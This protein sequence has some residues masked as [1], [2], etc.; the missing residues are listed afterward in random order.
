[1]LEDDSNGLFI[2][3][4]FHKAFLQVNEDGSEAAAATTV[5][6]LGRSIN[7]NR[8][9][10][11]ANRPFLLLIRESTINTLLFIGRVADPC[12]Q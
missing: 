11:L 6:A 12:D 8:E 10:F 4:A 3:D 2:S 5:V 1:M 9:V 7:M